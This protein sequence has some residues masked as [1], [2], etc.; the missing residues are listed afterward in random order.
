MA[1]VITPAY[2]PAPGKVN[3][4]SGQFWQVCE[5]A[6]EAAQGS[7]RGG[8]SSTGDVHVLKRRGVRRLPGAPPDPALCQP[9]PEP[10]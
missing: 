2:Y 8:D 10:S 7:G 4:C 9:L 5:Q 3:N 1:N 6:A